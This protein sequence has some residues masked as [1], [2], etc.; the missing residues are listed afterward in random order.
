MNSNTLNITIEVDDKGTPKIKKLGSEMDAASKKG[1]KGFKR[2]NKSLGD[3]NGTMSTAGKLAVGLGAA[4]AAIGLFQAAKDALALADSYT[5]LDNKLKLVTTSGEDLAAVQDGLYELS[6]RSH[7]AYS[8]SVDLY[9]RFARATDSM[10]TS[11]EELLR[12]TETLNKATIISGATQ[13]EA[14]ASL[15]LYPPH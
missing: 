7:A 5:L 4:F 6:L 10:G 9:S 13:Q 15:L 8:T 12:I 14:A 3:F 1:E 2:T 11:Q